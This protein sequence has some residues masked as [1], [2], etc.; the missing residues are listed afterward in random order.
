MI[1]FKKGTNIYK[2]I[3]IKFPFY[4]YEMHLFNYNKIISVLFVAACLK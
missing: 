4:S 3:I 1:F 2:I